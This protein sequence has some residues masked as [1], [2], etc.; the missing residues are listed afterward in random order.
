MGCELCGATD[1]LMVEIGSCLCDRQ[2]DEERDIA[3][4]RE[5]ALDE[6]KKEADNDRQQAMD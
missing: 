4:E 2:F 6:A 1:A 3:L 5:A